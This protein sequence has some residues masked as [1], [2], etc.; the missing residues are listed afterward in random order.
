MLPTLVLGVRTEQHAVRGSPGWPGG[1]HRDPT[2]VFPARRPRPPSG[3]ASLPG[4]LPS[5]PGPDP[6]PPT[7]LLFRPSGLSLGTEPLGPGVALGP[8]H[9]PPSLPCQ[10]PQLPRGLTPPL[11]VL[12]AF[13]HG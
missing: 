2:Q 7:Q 11:A 3:V 8:G 6:R 12:G 13:P 5:S 10:R 1:A 9:L 4:S